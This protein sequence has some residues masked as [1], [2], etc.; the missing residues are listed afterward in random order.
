MSSDEFAKT[1]A[2]SFQQATFW[3]FFFFFFSRKQALTLHAN[4]SPLETICMNCQ[5]LYSEKNKKKYTQYVNC[6]ICQDSGKGQGILI[7]RLNWSFAICIYLNRLHFQRSDS[8]TTELCMIQ[9]TMWE[10][11]LSGMRTQQRLWSA[12]VFTRYSL[13]GIFLTQSYYGPLNGAKGLCPNQIHVKVRISM[14][15]FK[16]WWAQESLL[17]IRDQNKHW[18]WIACTG[19][20][21]KIN[22]I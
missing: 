12:R 16:F 21:P 19:A 8:Y 17:P 13:A 20:Q 6:W 11:Q 1:V 7:F 5:S 10:N 14:D 22:S 4:L 2:T 18:I 15:L 3:I 9:S